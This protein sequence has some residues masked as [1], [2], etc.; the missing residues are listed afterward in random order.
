MSYLLTQCADVREAREAIDDVVIA[1]VVTDTIGMP[2]PVHL[3]VVDPGGA[4]VTIEFA[5]VTRIFDNTLRVLTN[6]PTFDWHEIN[7]RNYVNL[8]PVALPARELASINFAPLGAGSGMMGLPGDFTPPSRFVRAVAWTQTARPTRD[9]RD[10]VYE[11][12]RQLDNF[13]V[14][15]GQAEGSTADAAPM[16][17]AGMRSSTIWTVAY[18]LADRALYYHTQHNRRV[19]KVELDR[20]DIDALDGQIITTPMDL[21]PVEDIEDR[22]ADLR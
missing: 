18:D 15:L 21:E 7:L 19:R 20:V 13:N 3:L 5:G 17:I 4:A 6:A 14:P 9:A 11:V 12:F 10:G 1:P 8:S 16:T 22:T 2:A